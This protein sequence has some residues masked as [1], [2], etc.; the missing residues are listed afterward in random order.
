MHRSKRKKQ[1]DKNPIQRPVRTVH[2]SVHMIVHICVTQY[3]TEQFWWSSLLSSRQLSLIR[4]CLMEGR[5]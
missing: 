5:S 3:S 4:C 2:M 1:E